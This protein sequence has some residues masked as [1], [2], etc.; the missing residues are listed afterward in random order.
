MNTQILIK[1][2][3]GKQFFLEKLPQK[4][5]ESGKEQFKPVRVKEKDID[6]LRDSNGLCL[7]YED[8]CTRED[9]PSWILDSQELI[10]EILWN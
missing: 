3:N 1:V 6:S 8:F 5:W 4:F 7:W 9:L 10:F 2:T